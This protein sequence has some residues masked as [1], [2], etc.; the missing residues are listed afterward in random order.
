MQK[1]LILIIGLV[2]FNS[3]SSITKSQMNQSINV[4]I[5]SPMKAKI[6]VDMSRQLTGYASGGYLFH[7]FKVSGDTKFAKEIR[8]NGE[9]G[10]FFSFLS[11]VRTVQSAAAYNAIRGTN[12]DILVNPQYVLEEN[13]WNPFYKQIKVKV[14]GFPG[15]IVSITNTQ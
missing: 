11:R 12:A 13:H 8:F 9:D 1:I 10:G 3:C 14:T 2:L 7:L 6:D 5:D 15:K 4:T